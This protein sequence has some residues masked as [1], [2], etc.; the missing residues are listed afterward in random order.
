MFHW[1]SQSDFICITPSWVPK[2]FLIVVILLMN[3]P[4]IDMSSKKLGKAANKIIQFRARIFF[5]IFPWVNIWK[6]LGKLFTANLNLATRPKKLHALSIDFS[7]VST[8]WCKLITLCIPLLDFLLAV[9]EFL[10]QP[11]AQMVGTHTRTCTNN[12]KIDW[13]NLL[14][15]ATP[16]HVSI[17][18]WQ[19]SIEAFT[20]TVF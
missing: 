4:T 16:P 19:N 18:F 6:D 20:V 3:L 10:V 11:I 15:I 12:P 17:F 14:R 8:S 2:S 5:T 9:A 1:I 13:A 7:G